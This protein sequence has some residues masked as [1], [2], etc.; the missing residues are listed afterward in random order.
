MSHE[1][2]AISKSTGK[3]ISEILLKSSDQ[4]R[5]WLLYESLGCV[6]Y[7]SGFCGNGKQKIISENKLKISLSKF[8]YLIGEPECEIENSILSSIP[9]KRYLAILSKILV[10]TGINPKGVGTC[11]DI[12][13]NND[14]ESFLISL[15]DKNDV[16]IFFG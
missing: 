7:N 4:G 9:Y 6:A 2:I 1:I 11:L 14:I 15:Q 16:I 8:Y 5:S 13:K 12:K 3:K 10:T